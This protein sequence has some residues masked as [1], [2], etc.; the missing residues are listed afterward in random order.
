MSQNTNTPS[1]LTDAYKRM[2]ER[3]QTT[4]EGAET[5]TAS[6]LHHAVELAKEKAAELGELTR[7]EAVKVG[8][9]VKRDIENAAHFLAADEESEFAQWLR[10]DIERVEEDILESF[11]SVADQT[12]LELLRL[13]HQA[14]A[15]V[16]Y[17]TGEVTGIGALICTQCGHELHFFGPGHI[18]PCGNCKG[19]LFVRK[20]A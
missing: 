16:T 8:D 2:L 10:F 7:E 20:E 5:Q 17:H 13:E 9:Y 18:P 12:K 15:P 4:L 11:L 1:K 3:V 6:R 14:L 19:T